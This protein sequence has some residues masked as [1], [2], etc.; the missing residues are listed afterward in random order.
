MDD[1]R[2]RRPGL[3]ISTFLG[4]RRF[5]DREFHTWLTMRW[6]ECGLPA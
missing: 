2:R 4:R 5:D 1:L 3:T 6:R